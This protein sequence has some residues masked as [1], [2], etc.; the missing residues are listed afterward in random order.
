M[1]H[2]ISYRNRAT[3]IDGFTVVTDRVDYNQPNQVFPLHPENQFFIDEL[4]ILEEE[5]M[6]A[7]VLELGLGSG[8]LSIAAARRGAQHVVGLEINP[9][10]RMFTG[11]N[12]LN[13]GLEDIIEI[14]NGDPEHIFS[15]VQGE[16]FDYFMSNPP[17]EPTPPGV[18]DY[19]THSSGGMYG[20]DVTEKIIAGIQH[21]LTENGH[22]QIVTFAPGDEQ[23]PFMLVNLAER[24]LQ[25]HTIINVNPEKICFDTFVDRFHDVSSATS[26]QI[27]SMK[28]Q[29]QEDDVSHLY[30]CM[31]HYEQGTQSL[32]VQ[33][34]RKIY[35][36]WDLP[37]DSQVPMGFQE[38]RECNEGGV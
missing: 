25:G 13:N 35:S 12:I 38:N 2:A 4:G 21:H 23:G 8:V 19:F 34:S 10:A 15:P 9:R 29:A 31:L 26:E 24:Y 5:V 32:I 3:R 22:A 7:R 27:S 1:N 33:P 14:R 36:N 20:L 6:G 37:L 16:Q 11:Y 18:E 28:Q 17:F 30:L